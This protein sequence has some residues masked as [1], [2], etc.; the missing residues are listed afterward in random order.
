MLNGGISKS[1]LSTIYDISESVLQYDTK[2]ITVQFVPAQPIILGDLNDYSQG[3][4]NYDALLEFYRKCAKTCSSIDLDYPVW[5]I[6]SEDRIG[7]CKWTPPERFYLF[8]PEGCDRKPAGLY[9]IGHT[10][11]DYMDAFKLFER[12]KQ[13]ISENNFE[14]CGDAYEEYPINELSTTSGNY[15]IRVMIPVKAK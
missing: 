5:G 8:H 13:Y 10:C 6:I 2:T 15:L 7:D 1:L 11:G 9:A 14:I 3:Q 4:S 12:M